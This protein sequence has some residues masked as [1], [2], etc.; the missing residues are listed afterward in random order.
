MLTNKEIHDIVDVVISPDAG[1]SWVA[2]NLDMATVD[3]DEACVIA[4]GRGPSDE[5]TAQVVAALN[6]EIERGK[7]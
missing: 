6:E 3:I 2:K 5:E 4:I 1:G 7:S